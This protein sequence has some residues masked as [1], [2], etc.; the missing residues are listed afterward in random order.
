MVFTRVLHDGLWAVI[1]RPGHEKIVFTKGLFETTNEG[2]IDYLI[3]LGYAHDGEEVV[4]SF[5]YAVRKL[6]NEGE[7]TG[8]AKKVCDTKEQAETYMLEN[9][10]D[11]DAHGIEERERK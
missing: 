7:F 10:L 8:R 5:D 2:E 9:E 3:D 4:I 6:N 11:L 1:N